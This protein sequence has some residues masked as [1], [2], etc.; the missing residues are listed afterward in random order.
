[1]GPTRASVVAGICGC[2]LC[3]SIGSPCV[4]PAGSR[5]ALLAMGR[6][7]LLRQ[8]VVPYHAGGQ[9]ERETKNVAGQAA[10]FP[11]IVCYLPLAGGIHVVSGAFPKGRGGTHCSLT[12]SRCFLPCVLWDYRIRNFGCLAAAALIVLTTPAHCCL[13]TPCLCC[14]VICHPATPWSLR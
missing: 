12:A 9:P 6:G 3:T 14:E 10:C 7:T 5:R 13:A 1:M 2:I 4:L 11:G 8:H